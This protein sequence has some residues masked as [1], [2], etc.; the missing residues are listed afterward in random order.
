[1]GHGKKKYIAN[2]YIIVS[3]HILVKSELG[4]AWQSALTCCDR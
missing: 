1:M 3:Q 4:R 2:A